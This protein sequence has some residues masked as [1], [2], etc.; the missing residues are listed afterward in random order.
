MALLS[1]PTPHKVSLQMSPFDW[2]REHYRGPIHDMEKLL[3]ACGLLATTQ[4]GFP[5]ITVTLKWLPNYG[6]IS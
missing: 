4:M 2:T 1:L 6:Y 5:A 3:I